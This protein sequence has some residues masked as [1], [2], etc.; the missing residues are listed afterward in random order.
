MESIDIANP[1]SDA[2]AKK[3]LRGKSAAE[4]EQLEDAVLFRFMQESDLTQKVDTAQFM[5]K[6]RIKALGQ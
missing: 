1:L 4:I 2:E 3:Q 6:L 5:E